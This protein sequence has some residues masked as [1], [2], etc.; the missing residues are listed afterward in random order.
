MDQGELE[1]RVRGTGG[2]V[3]RHGAR[4]LQR[5]AQQARHTHP[6]RSEGRTGRATHR[7]E[8]CRLCVSSCSALCSG[9]LA[10]TLSGSLGMPLLRTGGVTPSTG[11]ARCTRAIHAYKSVRGRGGRGDNLVVGNLEEVQQRQRITHGGRVAEDATEGAVRENAHEFPVE[12]A[13]HT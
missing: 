7:S 10:G 9:V 3:Q 12:Y 4:V 1:Q 6:A 13:V 11:A 8:Y 5:G 2:V